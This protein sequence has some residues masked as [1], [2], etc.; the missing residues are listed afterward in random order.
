MI[1][2]GL[3]DYLGDRKS[4]RADKNDYSNVYKSKQ[5]NSSYGSM[6]IDVLQNRKPTLVF[7]Y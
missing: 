6:K 3:G 4:E 1:N 2:I 5:I 7:K